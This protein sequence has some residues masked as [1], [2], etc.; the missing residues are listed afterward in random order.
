M[1][2][3]QQQR[4]DAALFETLE[5]VRD[6]Q[7]RDRI[8]GPSFLG[9]RHQQRACARV[10][11]RARAEPLDRA[12]VSSRRDRCFGADHPYFAVAR[13]LDCRARARLDHADDRHHRVRRDRIER[14]RAGRVAG[15]HQH[16]D[17][18]GEQE[19]GVLL[20]V[21]DDDFVGFR[22]VGKPR[23]VAEVD[24]VFVGERRGQRFQDGESA[25]AGIEHADGPVDRRARA[26]N[27]TVGSRDR[28]KACY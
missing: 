15:D 25:D 17:S 9:Q 1:G 18:L 26:A 28:V 14:D 27:K 16:L 5:V 2:A 7:F 20:R 13:G 3:S 11:F 10:D 8:V 6:G 4:V 12:R 23:R 24:E 19:P 21:A 22:A